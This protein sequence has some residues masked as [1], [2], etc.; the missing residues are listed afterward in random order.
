MAAFEYKAL[1]A[2]GRQKKGVLEADTA[3]Q[4]RQQ[5]REQGMI[6]V[7]VVQ[8]REREKKKS[9]GGFQLRRGIST[10]ELSLITRQ[11]ATLV[12]ASMPLEE[13][14]KAVAEQ[15]EKPRLK[16]ML[17]AIRSRVVEGYTLS[18]SLAEYPH[19]F[20]QLFRAMVAAGEKS[21]HLDTVLNRLAD[22]TEN[23]QKMRSKLQQAM[24][25]PTMLTLIAI[26]VVAFLLATVV[27]KIVDQ[28]VQMGQQLPTITEILLAA[29][30]FV[31]NWGLV[32][33]LVIAVVVILLKMALKRPDF[34]LKWDRWVM[35]LPVIGKVAR[36]LS[37][38]RFARTLSIC[39]SS[40]IPLLE[41]MKV[42]S[43]VMTNTW[44]NQQIREAADKVREGSS[45]RVSLEQTKI[46]PPMMLHMIASGERS[47]E[48]EQMLTRAAD[49]QDRDFESLVN[50]ALGI[51]EPLLI[52]A[53]AGIVMFI[54]I[55]TLM[56]I[57]ALNNMVGM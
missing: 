30:D 43:D 29:S 5:L 21:G 54:V 51:F 45:L 35:R 53:M 47:G 39:T 36:G 4:I 31:Q 7:E 17:L 15:S 50:M 46:F 23:R 10:N 42:A 2:K 22:Y 11:L 55:A 32:V 24:I 13:C 28:F 27:P 14:L 25:Y 41:G 6:P 12:Q 56:P 18:D 57:I 33:L 48:L 40:A 16:N 52:V 38:S 37:T 9:S 49:N 8:T 1:D 20:D 44:V 26:A 34:R 3:R 19:I